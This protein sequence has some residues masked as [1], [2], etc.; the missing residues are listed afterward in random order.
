MTIILFFLQFDWE[1]FRPEKLFGGQ[2]LERTPAGF[3]IVYL[4]GFAVL[5]V[6]LLLS[7]LSN[8]RRPKFAF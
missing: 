3:S 2:V 5:T 1:K 6:F 8:F 4:I 7:F